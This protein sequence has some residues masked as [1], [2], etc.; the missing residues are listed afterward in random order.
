L[1]FADIEETRPAHA[2]A[3]RVP[4]SQRADP[5]A[6]CDFAKVATGFDSTRKLRSVFLG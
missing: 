1:D 2:E 4:L 3:S 5:V 6:E